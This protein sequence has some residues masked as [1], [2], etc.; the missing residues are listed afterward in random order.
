M[1]SRDCWWGRQPKPA[2][3]IMGSNAKSIKNQIKLEIEAPEDV[4]I[5]R[6]EMYKKD[7]V[8]NVLSSKSVVINHIKE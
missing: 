5:N 1:L 2:L 3:D 6:G 7:R 8:G 4:T